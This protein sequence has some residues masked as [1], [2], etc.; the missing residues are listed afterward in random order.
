MLKEEIRR[1]E[2]NQERVKHLDNQICSEYFKNIGKK[3]SNLPLLVL[4]NS[5]LK[6]LAPPKVN[7]ERTQLLPVLQTI[8]RLDEREL[9]LVRR[10]CATTTP[11]DDGQGES[12]IGSTTGDT[13]AGNGA[14]LMDWS[15]LFGWK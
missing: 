8:L 7:D 5:V 1:M 12:S 2:R 14:N 13:G 3:P 9:E 6:F 4:F 15:S 11:V 10:S